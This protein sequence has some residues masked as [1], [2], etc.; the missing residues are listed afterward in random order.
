[1]DKIVIKGLKVFA[2]HGVNAVEKENGQNFIVDVILHADLS[3]A[4]K[5]DNLSDTINYATVRKTITKTLTDNRYDLIE[6]AAGNTAQAILTEF[7]KVK[8][9]EITLKKPE[10][11]MNAEFDYVAVNIKREQLA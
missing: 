11:P 3:S 8:T 1:M 10:A 6:A 7:P 2:Y 9:V 5:S 4:C